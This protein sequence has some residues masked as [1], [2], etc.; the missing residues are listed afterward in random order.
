H[1]TV[2]RLAS[3]I[4]SEAGAARPAE[5][6]ITEGLGPSVLLVDAAD[7]PAALFCIHP[8]GGIAWCYGHLGRALAKRRKIYGLQ[9]DGLDPDRPLP[10]SLTAMAADYAERIVALQ[11]DGPYHLLGWSVGGIVAQSIAA[12]LARRGLG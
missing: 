9:A 11:K 3:H 10:V 8:A 7:E 12:E 6:T 4:E 5:A 1:P 2:A